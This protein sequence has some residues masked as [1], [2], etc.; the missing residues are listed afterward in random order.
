MKDKIPASVYTSHEPPVRQSKWFHK[1]IMIPITMAMAI[2]ELFNKPNQH[3]WHSCG[4]DE[5]CPKM[6]IEHSFA[7]SGDLLVLCLKE[8]SLE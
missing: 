6:D 7:T 8:E 5:A 1:I 3:S 2:R 4:E